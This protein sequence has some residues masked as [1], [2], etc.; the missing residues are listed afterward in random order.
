MSHAITSGLLLVPLRRGHTG[1]EW[2]KLTVKSVNS[3]GFHHQALQIKYL[4]LV[5]QSRMEAKF[6]TFYTSR[7]PPNPCVK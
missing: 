2:R 1:I 3:N 4:F 7:N 6:V 5:S